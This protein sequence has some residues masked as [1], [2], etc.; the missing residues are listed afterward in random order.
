MIR[1]K[2]AARDALTMS[3]LALLACLSATAFSATALDSLG[4]VQTCVAGNVPQQTVAQDLAI[5]HA[6]RLGKQRRMIGRLFVR[7][8]DRELLDTVMRMQEPDELRNAAY[9]MLEG[10][11][12]IPD[13]LLGRYDDRIYVYLP[14]A[15]KSRKINPGAAAGQLFGTNLNY[16]DIKHLFGSVSGG[17]ISK[18]EDVTLA[19][20]RVYPLEIVP[21]EKTSPYGRV[22]AHI[23]ALTCLTLQTDFYARSGRLAKQLKMNPE[24]ISREDGRFV[25]HEYRMDELSSKEYTMLYL[26]GVT[27]DES[28]KEEFFHPDVFHRAR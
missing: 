20:R 21:N 22:V 10:S 6:D 13:K 7:R 16:S 14:A 11:G 9:L 12:Y 2:T 1:F 3:R 28:L 8:N 18:G 19:G 15:R 24:K 4:E 17:K 26:G 23:D 5:I 25:G 27:Y